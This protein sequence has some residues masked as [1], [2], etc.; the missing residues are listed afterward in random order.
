MHKVAPVWLSRN[1][2]YAQSPPED[3]MGGCANNSTK[4]LIQWILQ[5]GQVCGLYVT[6][7][8]QRPGRSVPSD[9]AGT[10]PKETANIIHQ[11]CLTQTPTTQVMCSISGP[12]EGKLFWDSL[13]GGVDCGTALHVDK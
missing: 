13:Q 3:Q 5:E 9:L 1:I 7:T 10:V 6:L 2:Q 4:C 8:T 12:E 11:D